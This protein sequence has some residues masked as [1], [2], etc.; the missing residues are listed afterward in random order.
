MMNLEQ[1]FN[2]IL[3]TEGYDAWEEANAELVALV[4]A[5]EVASLNN[6]EL[7]L[8]TG[9]AEARNID[10]TAGRILIGGFCTYFQSW[11]WDNFED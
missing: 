5:E 1:Y 10:L 2:N 7:D 9:W 6:E 8:I 3:A 4:E 11:Y